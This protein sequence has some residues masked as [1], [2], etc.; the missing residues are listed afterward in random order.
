[1]TFSL[2]FPDDQNGVTTKYLHW[3]QRSWSADANKAS[4]ACEGA[5]PLMVGNISF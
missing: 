4:A 5:H 1:M 2:I 3:L